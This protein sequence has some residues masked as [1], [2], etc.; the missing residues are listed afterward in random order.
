MTRILKY[1]LIGAFLFSLSIPLRSEPSDVEVST[2]TLNDISVSSSSDPEQQG[3]FTIKDIIFQGNTL[4][5]ARALEKKVKTR[6]KKELDRTQLQNDVKLL[7]ETGNFDDVSVAVQY[8]GKNATVVYT[9][10][11]RPIIKRI[12][13]KGDKRIRSSA[14]SDKLQ[15]QES[16]PYD[17]YKAALDARSIIEHYRDEGYANVQVEHYTTLD[18]RKKEL[19]LTFFIVEGERVTV[20]SIQVEGAHS[21]SDKKITKQLVSRRK[22][23]FKE[24]NIRE[25]KTKILEFYRNRGHLDVT[26]ASYESD[27]DQERNQATLRIAIDEGPRYTVGDVIIGT[28]TLFTDKELRK[29]VTLRSNRLF[30]QSKLEETVVNIKT[31][32]DDKGYLRTEVVPMPL[33]DPERG[34]VNYRLDIYESSVV[35]VDGV[36]VDGNTYTKSHVIKREVLLK[37]GDVFSAGRMRRSVERIY[38]LGFLE[39]VQVDVQ[40]PRSADLADIIFS[41]REGKPGVLSAGAGFSS[42]D[43]FVGTLQVSHT[44]LFGTAQR[45]N[46]QYEFGARRQN[47]EIGWTDPWFLG[48]RMSGGVDLFNTIRRRDYPGERSAYRERRQGVSTRLGP[49]IS[50]DVGLLFAYTL[51]RTEVYDVSDNIKADLFPTFG[52]PRDQAAFTNSISQMKSSVLSEIALDTRDNRFDATRGGRNSLSVEVAG[53]P[54]GGDIN[55]YKPQVFTS[56]YFPTFWKFVF[57][58]SGRASWVNSYS[59]SVD[60]PTSERFFL[61]GA[62]TV[63]GYKQSSIVPRTIEKNNAGVDEIRQIPGRIMT[64]FN[65]EYKFPIVQEGNRTIFQGAFFLDVGGAWLRTDDIDFTTGTSEN[66]MKA[67]VGFGFRF[68]T[69]V[70]PIRLDFGMPLNPRNADAARSA[71]ERGLQPYFTIGN[72]F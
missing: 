72:I 11:E 1:V 44:N 68:K 36:Y 17:R 7:F 54:F 13:Y 35:Y 43:R 64:L 47:F 57:S 10:V 19:I 6:R 63:R 66:R 62:D 71:D 65:A 38:N 5:K 21:Y 40:Q 14:F 25:D 51:Q 32:Y 27:I 30:D 53:G 55:L 31:L 24:E 70:F 58:V 34:Q 41:V 18:E 56:W 28:S 61:G 59:P 69:P 67:G 12:D 60:V 48:Y 26:V 15:S 33:R 16:N 8:E 22:K 4:N 39:D 20:N 52:I 42:V 9:V 37:P 29:A 23:T 49:R 46:V 3:P 2:H 50:D 45:L